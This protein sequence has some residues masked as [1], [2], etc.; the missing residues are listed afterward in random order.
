M[1]AELEL[2]WEA[3]VPGPRASFSFVES[4][5]ALKR[6]KIKGDC[7]FNKVYWEIYTRGG[8]TNCVDI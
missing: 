3:A 1:A 6:G 7:G 2:V 8:G 5:K 4:L